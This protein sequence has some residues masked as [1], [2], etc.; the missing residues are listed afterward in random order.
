MRR[1]LDELA[2][3]APSISLCLSAFSRDKDACYS[4]LKGGILY[5][6]GQW[7]GHIISVC[8]VLCRWIGIGNCIC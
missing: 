1:I 8:P 6:A 2:V 7:A 3:Y 4:N 5:G